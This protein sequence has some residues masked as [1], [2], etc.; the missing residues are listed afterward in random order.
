VVLEAM[1]MESDIHFNSSG[2]VKKIHV[3]R[4]IAFKK[5]APD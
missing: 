1:K 2:K 4:G 3:N 5:R